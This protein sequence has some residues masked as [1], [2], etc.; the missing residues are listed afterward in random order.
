MPELHV[1][2]VLLVERPDGRDMLKWALEQVGFEVD[3]ANDG[4]SALTIAAARAPAV[5]IIEIVLPG[6]DGW[7][8]AQRLRDA[9]GAA[10]RLV[11]LTS[12]GDPEDRAQSAAAGFNVHLVKPVRPGKVHDTIRHL[13]AA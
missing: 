12:L 7:A 10:I 6:M 9:Y 4:E 8:L 1:E 13:L 11:A 5:A 3:L 2:R